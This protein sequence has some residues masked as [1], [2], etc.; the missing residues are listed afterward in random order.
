MYTVYIFTSRD[1]GCFLSSHLGL[2]KQRSLDGRG[3]LQLDRNADLRRIPFSLIGHRRPASA[4][5]AARSRNGGD[6]HE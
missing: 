1:L 2:F 4:A 5:G 6:R 3:I